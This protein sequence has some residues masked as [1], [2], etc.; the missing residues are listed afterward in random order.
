[1]L[2][3]YFCESSVKH[4]RIIVVVVVSFGVNVVVNVAVNVAGVAGG[5]CTH[6]NELSN[7]ISYCSV[8]C[9]C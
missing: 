3:L 2:N 1:M 4:L 8:W 9:F 5:S 7:T 6:I